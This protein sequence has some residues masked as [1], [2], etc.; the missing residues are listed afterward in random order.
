MQ[1]IDLKVL[2]KSVDE[3]KSTVDYLEILLADDNLLIADIPAPEK[4]VRKKR[5]PKKKVDPPNPNPE[6]EPKKPKRGRRGRKQSAES[7]PNPPLRPGE[8]PV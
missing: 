3:I 8:T 2:R 6:P 4:K 7:Y 1:V 5:V